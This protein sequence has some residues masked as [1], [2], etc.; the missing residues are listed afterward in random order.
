[1]IGKHLTMS[2]DMD[3]PMERIRRSYALTDDAHRLLKRASL[4]YNI[5]QTSILELMIR[6]YCMTEAERKAAA[7]ELF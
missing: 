6:K 5:P 7:N 1:M 3:T 4:H 2:S